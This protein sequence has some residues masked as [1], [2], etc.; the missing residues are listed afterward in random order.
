MPALQEKGSGIVTHLALACLGELS[1]A[2][3]FLW[4]QSV[5]EGNMREDKR[6]QGKDRRHIE[7]EVKKLQITMSVSDARH[8]ASCVC[9]E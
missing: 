3:G 7:G 4:L 2:S 1:S 8:Q 5:L 9:L 6:G